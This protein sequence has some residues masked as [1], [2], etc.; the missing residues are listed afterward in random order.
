MMFATVDT[1]QKGDHIMKENMIRAIF[2]KEFQEEARKHGMT[3]I[4]YERYLLEKYEKR[5]MFVLYMMGRSSGL[6]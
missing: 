1:F 2:V 4:Q 5:K 3:P 6:F